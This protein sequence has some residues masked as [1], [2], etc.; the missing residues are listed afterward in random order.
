MEERRARALLSP[1]LEVPTR[2]ILPA[3]AFSIPDRSAGMASGKEMR[4]G[5]ARIAALGRE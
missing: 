3:D 2:R 4:C 5:S 1:P